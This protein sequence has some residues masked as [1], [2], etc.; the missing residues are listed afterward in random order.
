[1]N[2]LRKGLKLTIILSA[3]IFVFAECGRRSESRKYKIGI[4]Q[5]SDDDWRNKM[6][7]EIER[8]IMMHSDAEVE[9][10]SADD[11]NEKQI[12]DIR[13]FLDNKFDILIVAPNEADA[14]TPII[15][16]AYAGGTPVVLFDRNINGDCFTAWQ[17]ADN[18]EIGRAAANYAAR[19]EDERRGSGKVL[20]LRGRPG[21]TPAR[22]RNTGFVKELANYPELQ[23]V[24]S[25]IGNWT[26][27]E[28]A[29]VID[30]LYNMYPDVDI[31]YAHNDRMAVAAADVAVKRGIKPR[32]IGVDA[33]PD[34]GI[35]AVRDSVI[36]ATFLYPT[37][38]YRLIRT[39]LSILK[40]EGYER[41]AKLPSS[42]AVD[43][44][45]ADILL[46][47]NEALREE[48]GKLKLL[49]DQIDDFW[50]K[51]SVQTSLMYA[52]IA[53]LILFVGLLF[54][55]LRLYWANRRHQRELEEHNRIVE[56][57]RDKQEYLNK[58][59]EKATQSKLVFFT[60]VSHDLR[61]PL[62][63][64]SEPVDQLRKASNL[65]TLQKEL[66][67]IAGKNVRILQR[68]INQ[69]LDFR[70]YEN[71]KMD[72]HL[73]EVDFGALLK[74]WADSFRALA[75]QR[76]IHF[77]VETDSSCDLQLAVDTEK[78]ERVF[79][80]LVSN[81]FKHT[82]ANGHIYVKCSIKNNVL[83]L[84]V[85]DTGAGIPEEDLPHIFERFFQVE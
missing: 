18:A 35:K 25:A 49:K 68:L 48:T 72:L 80:N 26:Y 63:L 52:L 71:G 41:I 61:T 22:E 82:P 76:D 73:T 24:G 5:C 33:A 53:I 6:N 79:F 34:I 58:E 28:A 19:M 39:A 32:I 70:K 75:R 13:Y 31:V 69:I 74:E 43:S 84:I 20:E 55:L 83:T 10:R 57:E 38:G 85:S 8:E 16:E 9:I 11:S 30:S 45:N 59:L 37:D 27:E 54:F 77:G 15:K 4:S 56:E 2:L 50:E 62:T 3:I 78:M 14:I 47:Q 36:D 7:E 51:H 65:T 23:L 64:I 29:P 44:S 67:D 40:G 42:S 12:S 21:S 81:A 66:M 1:M 46:I 17:G 60:N